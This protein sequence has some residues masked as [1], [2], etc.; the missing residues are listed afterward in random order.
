IMKD[1]Y[2]EENNIAIQQNC[3]SL[4]LQMIFNNNLCLNQHRY[5][6][7][8]VNKVAAVLLG[9]EN[10]NFPSYCFAICSYSDQLTTISV[11][12][13]YCNPI[14]YPLLFSRRNIG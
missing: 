10:K 1:A 7:P 13:K 4:E 11:I 5:N 12:N 14:S 8:R 6:I 3:S 9:P 2:K